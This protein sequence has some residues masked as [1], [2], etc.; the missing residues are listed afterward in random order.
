M[1]A[2][3]GITLTCGKVENVCKMASSMFLVPFA[4]RVRTQTSAPTQ[5]PLELSL[6]VFFNILGA[7]ADTASIEYLR[8]TRASS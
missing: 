7:R 3:E 4:P 8:P 2:R 6:F 5:A 1:C